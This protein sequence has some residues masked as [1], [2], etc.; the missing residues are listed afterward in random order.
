MLNHSVNDHKFITLTMTLP[1]L[2]VS[3]VLVLMLL[4]SITQS[5][6]VD[7]GQYDFFLYFIFSSLAGWCYFILIHVVINNLSPSVLAI[8]FNR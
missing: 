1:S 5:K 4:Y 2:S 8:D 7:V 3:T 6:H